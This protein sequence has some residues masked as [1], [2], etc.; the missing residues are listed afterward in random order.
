MDRLTYSTLCVEENGPTCRV[1]LHRPDAQNAINRA[2]I[3]ELGELLTRAS[4]SETTVVVLEGSPEVFCFG[5][6]FSVISSAARDGENAA[7]DPEPLFELFHQIA[8]GGFLSIAHVRGKANAGGVGFVAASDL[9][10]ADETA[11]FGLSELIFGLIP[12]VV[13]PFLIRRVGFQRAHYLAATTQPI[14]VHRAAEWGLVDA[15]Q[16]KSEALLR[17]HLVRMSRM[18]KKAVVRY[19]S[20]LSELA[21]IAPQAKDAALR[22]NREV[23]ADPDNVA[24]IRR[25]AEKALFPWE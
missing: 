22:V 15:Y 20:Y 1:Q 5:A 14:D 19:K 4:T 16:E 18:T 17:K 3:A 10:I 23:F 9:V 7:I 8:L 13:L 24:A 25:Y 2:M 21:F 12:A 6:D 11:V